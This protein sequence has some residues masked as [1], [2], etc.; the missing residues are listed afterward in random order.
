MDCMDSN[1]VGGIR[2]YVSASGSEGNSSG[3]DDD[4]LMRASRAA[5]EATAVYL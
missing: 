4:D 1:K 2:E 3:S 5:V